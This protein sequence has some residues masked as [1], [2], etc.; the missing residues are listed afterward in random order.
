MVRRRH[1]PTTNQR[2]VGNP[3][4][5]SSFSFHI[6]TFA[7]L[8]TFWKFWD[9]VSDKQKVG[10]IVDYGSP[11]SQRSSHAQSRCCQQSDER[12]CVYVPVEWFN[13]GGPAR[14]L[15]RFVCCV[16][17]FVFERASATS[18]NT[19]A[20]NNVVASAKCKQFEVIASRLLFRF[21]SQLATGV[22]TLPTIYLCT[23]IAIRI[24]FETQL[25]IPPISAHVCM[26]NG[27]GDLFVISGL[28]RPYWVP[29]GESEF[30]HS[31]FF[32]LNNSAT[33]CCTAAHT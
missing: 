28:L 20:V 19:P 12:L 26:S 11:S 8:S 24:S 25:S 6:F 27:G 31:G 4:P 17:T 30:S 1:Q 15:S 33:Y 2:K 22:A 23:S 13:A 9:G 29:R 32:F 16:F 18:I 21:V 5:L 10:E 14:L 3:P 7:Y